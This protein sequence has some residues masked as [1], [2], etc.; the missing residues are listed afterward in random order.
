MQ[1]IVEADT[2]I[3]TKHAANAKLLGW[4]AKQLTQSVPNFDEWLRVSLT[5]F[6]PY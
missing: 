1:K 6:F 2:N 3:F 5:Q 4:L